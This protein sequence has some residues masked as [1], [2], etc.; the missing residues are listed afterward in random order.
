MDVRARR[1]PA[2]ILVLALVLGSPARGAAD[3][4]PAL[5]P[6]SAWPPPNSEIAGRVADAAGT[7]LEG[8]AVSVW[9]PTLPGPRFAITTSAGLYRVAQLPAGVYSVA[10]ALDGFEAE[11]RPDV[12]LGEGAS[13]EVNA[14]LAE[15]SAEPVLPWLDR[16]AGVAV[17]TRSGRNL[18]A[19]RA[20]FDYTDWHLQSDNL[21]PGLKAQ[22]AGFG[23]PVRRAGEAGLDMGGPI[24]RDRASL[25][26]SAA[27]SVVDRGVIGFYTAACVAPDGTPV[28]GAAYRAECM[29]ADVTTFSTADLKL[30]W[31]WTPAHRTT[32]LWGV[33]DRHRPSRG[34][35]AFDRPEH[36]NRQEDVSF[37]QPVQIRHQ[38]TVSDR[39]VLDGAFVFSD[40]RFVLDFH[41]PGLADVQG[42]YDR[43]TLVNSRSGVRTEYSRP[44]TEVEAAGRFV[45]SGVLGGDHSTSFGVAFLDAPRR[46]WDQTG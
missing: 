42:A 19:G 18:F 23:N 24:L 14:R 27:R 46:Q 38:W 30:Q 10:F 40:G 32:A 13:A 25:W 34:A 7:P 29:N 31:R 2:L 41:D 36:T 43:F 17:I 39:L 45:S 12:G 33:A 15:W 6:L 20:R 35:S 9:G 22:G 11:E 16:G 3:G 21:T 44:K 4:S 5:S 37:I 28:A 8:V 26:G 1:S